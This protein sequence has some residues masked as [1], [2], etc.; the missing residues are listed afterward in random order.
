LE[1]TLFKLAH[2][3]FAQAWTALSERCVQVDT[4]LRANLQLDTEE[5]TLSSSLPAV[6]DIA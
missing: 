1:S 5:L 2:L 6:A 4:L 3:I